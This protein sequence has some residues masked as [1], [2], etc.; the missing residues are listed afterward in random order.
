[1]KEKTKHTTTGDGQITSVLLKKWT[2]SIVV[3]TSEIKFK[4]LL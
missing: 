1:V 2:W 4:L 3:S